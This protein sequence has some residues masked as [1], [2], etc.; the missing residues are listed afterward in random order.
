MP[1]DPDV[2]DIVSR[3]GINKLG[4]RIKAGLEGDVIHADGAQIGVF[5]WGDAANATFHAEGA[6]AIE[7]GHAQSLAGG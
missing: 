3:G 6:G 7:G 5:P 2:A 1:A 4:K